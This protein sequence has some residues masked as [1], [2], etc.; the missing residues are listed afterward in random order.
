M[1]LQ[2]LVIPPNYITNDFCFVLS[3]SQEVQMDT[4]MIVRINQEDET[5][6]VSK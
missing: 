2:L 3:G 6:S 4:I 1:Y 5:L